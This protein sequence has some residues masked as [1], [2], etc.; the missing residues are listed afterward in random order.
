[1]DLTTIYNEEVN[2]SSQF[3]LFQN[4]MNPIVRSFW[5]YVGRG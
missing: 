2:K 1:M 5:A 3:T 4:L